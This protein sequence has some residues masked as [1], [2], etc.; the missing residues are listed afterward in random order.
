MISLIYSILRKN[1]QTKE[2]KREKNQ[3]TELTRGQTGGFQ[4]AGG[5]GMGDREKGMKSTL[6]MR[7][8][9]VQNC[10]ITVLYP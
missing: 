10:G 1:K 7:R 6:I 4:G 9:K 5:W 2:K 8:T 3:Q